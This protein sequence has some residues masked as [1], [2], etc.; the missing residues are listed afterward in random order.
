MHRSL[1]CLSLLLQYALAQV[2]TPDLSNVTTAFSTA[3][4]VPDVLPSF[5]PEDAVNITFTD[6]ATM[7]NID[8]V[9]GI[10]LTM[11]RKLTSTT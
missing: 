1:L 4:I 5:S 6:P 3:Q 8:V 2:A 7:E 9:P 10:L 11:E